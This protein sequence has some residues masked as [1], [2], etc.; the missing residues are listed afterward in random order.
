MAD[1]PTDQLVVDREQ[2]RLH[3]EPEAALAV[4]RHRDAA[5]PVPERLDLLRVR[6]D[7]RE[8]RRRLVRIEAGL[9]EQL[10][11]VPE[12]RKVAQV[13]H[14]VVLA[15]VAGQG[16]VARA[17]ILLVGKRIDVLGDVGQRAEPAELGDV[18]V[19][20]PDHVRNRMCADRRRELRCVLVGRGLRQHDLQAGMARVELLDQ[21]HADA[22]CRSPRPELDG[23]CCTHAERG[24]LRRAPRGRRRERQSHHGHDRKRN[25]G[26]PFDVPSPH[27]F[28]TFLTGSD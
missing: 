11:V 1:R 20:Q 3:H 26:E 18:D 4:A 28:V 27:L 25:Q 12:H 16:E 24:L 5:D 6:E 7:L 2:V 19:V 17:E 22:A 14:A 21:G 9:L 15:V 8:V 23:S 13:R 10:L